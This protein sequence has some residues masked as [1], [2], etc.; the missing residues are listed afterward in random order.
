MTTYRF[1]DKNID[2]QKFEGVDHCLVSVLH[3]DRDNSIADVL[4]KFEPNNQV[5]LH[6]HKAQNN[7]FVIHGTHSLYHSDGKL[8]EARPV[9]SYTVTPASEEPHRECGQ[10]EEAIVFF[11]IRGSGVLYELLDDNEQAIASITFEDVVTFYEACKADN[12]AS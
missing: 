3:I 9:G 8:K 1:D 11:S 2:W 5:I 12:R 10:N 6:K 4:F 7:T